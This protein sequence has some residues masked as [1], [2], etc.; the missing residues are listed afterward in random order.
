MVGEIK[1]RNNRHGINPKS[2]S[3]PRQL[4]S[5]LQ[6]RCAHMHDDGYPPLHLLDDELRR[7]DP[8]LRRHHRTHPSRSQDKETMYPSVDFKL[9]EISNDFIIDFTVFGKGRDEGNIDPAKFWSHKV[10]SI[11][12]IINDLNH[13][14]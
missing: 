5:G 2:L 4:H 13:P 11:K 8:L 3:M 7:F 9:R 1:R 14:S 10:A 12:S 6:I